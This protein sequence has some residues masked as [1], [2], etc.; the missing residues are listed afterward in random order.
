MEGVNYHG[1]TLNINIGPTNTDIGQNRENSGKIVEKDK[2]KSSTALKFISSSTY[3]ISKS[4]LIGINYLS[5]Y[6][7]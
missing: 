6:Y 2:I 1:A 5:F 3:F 7:S 4:V